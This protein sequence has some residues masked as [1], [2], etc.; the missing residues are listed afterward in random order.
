MTTEE[1]NNMPREEYDQLRVLDTGRIGT[2]DYQGVAWFWN[3]K[4]KHALRDATPEQRVKVHAAFLAANLTPSGDSAKHTKIICN[5][6]P[7][8]M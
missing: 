7:T 3:T 1:L 4:Y 5:I 6:F 2:P 8:W